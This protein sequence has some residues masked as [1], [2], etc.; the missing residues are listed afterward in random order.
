M[1]DTV[2]SADQVLVA[3]EPDGDKLGLTL[4]IEGYRPTPDDVFEQIGYLLLDRT[5]GEYD[6]ETRIGY[7]EFQHGRPR[8]PRAFVPLAELPAIVDR[9]LGAW[10]VRH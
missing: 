7:I 8:H 6:V 3:V 5:L 9:F 2:V 10:G 4:L 1:G